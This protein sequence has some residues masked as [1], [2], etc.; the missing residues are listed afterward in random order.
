MKAAV[1]STLTTSRLQVTKKKINNR[2]AYDI[3]FIRTHSFWILFPC[4][5]SL[6]YYVL[7]LVPHDEKNDLYLITIIKFIFFFPTRS[8]FSS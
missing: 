8:S 1:E 2:E 7:A 4:V 5:F 6:S 3:A